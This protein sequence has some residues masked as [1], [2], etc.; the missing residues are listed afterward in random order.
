[1]TS[2]P[3]L[4][5]GLVDIKSLDL[6]SLEAFL[7]HIG[8]PA[9]KAIRIYQALWQRHVTD[10][11]EITTIAKSDHILSETMRFIF[12]ISGGISSSDGTKKFCGNTNWRSHR[13]CAHSR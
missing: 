3:T 4:A 12:R 6:P 2:F 5:S 7:Q 9:S 1:M 8:L 11:A 10:S 13:K